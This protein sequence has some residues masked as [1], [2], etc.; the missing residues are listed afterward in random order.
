VLDSGVLWIENVSLIFFQAGG[1]EGR[2]GE[3]RLYSLLSPILLGE[4]KLRA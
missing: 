2:S 1:G 3:V 4:L